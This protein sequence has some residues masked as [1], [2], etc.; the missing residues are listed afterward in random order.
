MPGQAPSEQDPALKAEWHTARD[1]FRALAKRGDDSI[2]G[3]QERALA[4]QAMWSS[5]GIV[6]A[7]SGD[8]TGATKALAASN[9]CGKLVIALSKSTLADRVL[10]LEVAV[11]EAKTAGANVRGAARA[12]KG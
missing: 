5:Y 7:D 12:R 8:P 1:A 4:E 3:Q 2:A 9:H 6:L 11:K 10:A